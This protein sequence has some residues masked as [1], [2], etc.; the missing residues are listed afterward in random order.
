MSKALADGFRWYLAIVG[1]NARKR[2]TGC[3]CSDIRVQRMVTTFR[4]R[5]TLSGTISV[6][7]ISFSALSHRD[8][9]S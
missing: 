6:V 5:P 1:R 2:I 9:K 4:L 7:P 8:V 3:I